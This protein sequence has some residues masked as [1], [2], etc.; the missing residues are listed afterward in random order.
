MKLGR[1]AMLRNKRAGEVHG[2]KDA[3]ELDVVISRE[4]DSSMTRRLKK[5][6]EIIENTTSG[7]INP[8]KV[9]HINLRILGSES[10]KASLGVRKGK[11]YYIDQDKLR[12]VEDF[13][14]EDNSGEL[15]ALQ[16]NDKENPFYID[17]DN[18]QLIAELS[19]TNR[20]F[21]NSRI[22]IASKIQ[23]FLGVRN[24]GKN[25]IDELTLPSNPDLL[26]AGVSRNMLGMHQVQEFLEDPNFFIKDTIYSDRTIDEYSKAIPLIPET[27]VFSGFK[28]ALCQRR[29]KHFVTTDQANSLGNLMFS[30][31]GKMLQANNELEYV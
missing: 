4:V 31:D 30:V 6:L 2:F 14:N 20:E 16:L 24:L 9:G 18:D 12:S 26:L 8:M 29:P 7:A 23:Q 27:I 10:L 3:S 13:I 15:M 22:Y 5:S 21:T 17:N 28:V 1:T 19:D 25:E 11:Q